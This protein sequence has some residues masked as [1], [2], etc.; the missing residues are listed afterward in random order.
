MSSESTDDQEYYDLDLNA[1]GDADRYSKT[2][3]KVN[4]SWLK[5]L[6]VNPFAGVVKQLQE[7]LL[8]ETA[9]QMAEASRRAT[10]YIVE[11]GES[12][13]QIQSAVKTVAKTMPDFTPL[14]SQVISETLHPVK[15]INSNLQTIF[16]AIRLPSLV[17]SWTRQFGDMIRKIFSFDYKKILSPFADLIEALRSSNFLLIVNASQGEKESI[18]QLGILWVKIKILYFKYCYLQGEKPTQE[19]FRAFLSQECREYLNLHEDD[20][21]KIYGFAKSVFNSIMLRLYVDYVEIIENKACSYNDDFIDLGKL[22]F[23]IEPYVENPEHGKVMFTKMAGQQIGTSAQTIR[24]Y[25]N[26]DLIDIEIIKTSHISALKQRT[27]KA[28]LLPYSPNLIHDLL[29]IKLDKNNRKLHRKQGV[30][31]VTQVSEL[32]GI[33]RKTLERWDAQGILTPERVNNIRYYTHEEVNQISEIFCKN[34]SPK[35]KALKA[36]IAAS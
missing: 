2:P 25:L 28:H 32:M 34:N 7:S 1:V 11:F 3:Q 29:K 30:Y 24:N 8:I 10:E 22:K 4:L 31:T 5:N 20:P 19:A 14:V 18:N 6:N 26:S 13:S 36:S 23:R 12:T 16:A 35:F 9:Q 15:N 17:S 21:A 33:S 27:L